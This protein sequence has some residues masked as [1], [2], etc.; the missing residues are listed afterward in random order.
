MAMAR[1]EKT[2]RVW[3]P[4]A[5]F[6]VFALVILGR[7]V[8]LQVIEHARY[9]EEAKTELRGDSTVY[10]RR[11]SIL[12][13]NGHALAVSVDT[14]DVYVNSRVWREPAR[15]EGAAKLL[16]PLLRRDAGQLVQTVRSSESLDVLLARDVSYETGQL[17][18]K[19]DPAGVIMLRNTARVHPEGDTGASVLGFIGRDKTG[20][21][22][23][24]ATY[25]SVLQG[26]PGRVIYERDTM[27][28]PI[29]FGQ[30]LA[31]DP[32]PG[33]ELVLTIDRYLQQ[34]AEE[35]LA[36][37]IKKHDARGGAIVMMDPTNGEI[38]A[39]ATTPGMKYSTLD[40]TDGSQM[41]L[42]KNRA[43]TDL[44]EPGSVMKVVT[45][46]AAIDRGVV[47]PGTEYVDNGVAD[48]YG[49]LIRNWDN[50]VYGPQTMTGVLEHSINTGAI[51]MAQ[52]LGVEAFHS[53]LD[54]FGF[55]KPTGIDL[56]GEATGI[57]RRPD[58]PGW[59]PVDL[60]TQS[61]GQSISVTPIQMA[62]AIAATINGGV[63]VKPHLV[64]A[65]VGAD[66]K[67]KE[68]PPGLGGRVISEQTS[69]TMR[70]MLNA[71]I[72]PEG[73]SHPAKPQDY[74]AGGKSGTANVPVWN[75][76]DDR[77]IAS[78]VGF[79]PLDAPRVLVLIKLDENDDLLTGTAAAG[80]V[81]AKLADQALHYLN[82]R[83]DA[84]KYAVVR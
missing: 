31:S 5:F 55:G 25:N 66:G 45:A 34:M 21:A 52:R 62:A 56:N 72:D 58:D 26:K 84:P 41:E 10:A 65:T 50:K 71:V 81:F 46:A 17:I 51:L 44:Y 43:V 83:P 29:P 76:Y 8:K 75:G 28:D 4:A 20:L 78:F 38:L 63:L 23:I 15:A 6:G 59:S 22:G 16:A 30:Y 67:R 47:S 3:V 61:F 14:W 82:V 19:A 1:A 64:K 80:P 69:A 79:A 40:L 2:R 60:A 74:S 68:M 37:A 24:E 53:Y 54:K 77:Q 48:V 36:E 13:R 33:Q 42:L 39:L 70:Q 12:D 73:R 49:T 27:G 35:A 7:L 18:L 11:G 32:V 57:M 9:A